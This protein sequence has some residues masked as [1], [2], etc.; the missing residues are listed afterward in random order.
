MYA[1]FQVDNEV[2]PWWTYAYLIW[3][4]PVFLLTDLLRY[5]PTLVLVGVAYV[6]TWALLLWA[7]GVPAMKAMQIMY[8]LATAGEISYFSYLYAVAPVKYFQRIASLNRVASLVGKFV[9]YLCGQ[10]LTSFSILDFFQLNI[11][12]FVSVCIALVI[13]ITLPRPEHSELFNQRSNSETNTNY[14]TPST[15]DERS[16]SRNLL[17]SL[18]SVV[19]FLYKEVKLIYLDRTILIWSVWWAFASCGN[20]QVGNYIQNLWHILTPYKH[21]RTR[22]HLYNGAVEAAGTLFSKQT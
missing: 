5:K 16:S 13:S 4:V 8:G 3:L 19:V 20:F 14:Q 7:Q 17:M 10:L 22:R 6:T 21:D 12:S 11:F 9:A 1:D 15:N 18:K 2:Y